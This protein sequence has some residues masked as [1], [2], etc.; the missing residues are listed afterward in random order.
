MKPQS[1]RDIK[2]ADRH[3]DIDRVLDAMLAVRSR[4]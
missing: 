3:V 4:R 1:R 2:K